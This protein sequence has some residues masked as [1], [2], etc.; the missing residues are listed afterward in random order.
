MFYLAPFYHLV[1]PFN[2]FMVVDADIEFKYG[3]DNLQN[4]FNDYGSEQL[5]S[6]APDMSPFYRTMLYQYRSVQ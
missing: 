2:K 1:F 5:Y 3:V 6:L 4:I